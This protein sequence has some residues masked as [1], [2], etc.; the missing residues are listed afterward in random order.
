MGRIEVEVSPMTLWEN[1][2]RAIHA[3]PGE[4]WTEG[5]IMLAIGPHL[6]AA[7]AEIAELKERLRVLHVG[8]VNLRMEIEK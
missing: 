1:C 3:I 7:D 4:T 5:R 2:R 8:I 6:N